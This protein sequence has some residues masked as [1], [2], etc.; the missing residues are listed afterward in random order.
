MD[1][2]GVGWGPPST[3]VEVERGREGGKSENVGAGL[4]LGKKLQ[5]ATADGVVS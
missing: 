3:G 4:G 5:G 2:G 1:E